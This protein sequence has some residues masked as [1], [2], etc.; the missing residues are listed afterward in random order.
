M[1]RVGCDREVSGAAGVRGVCV[2]GCVSG[3]GEGAEGFVKIDDVMAMRGRVS[4][5]TWEHEM[6]CFPPRFEDAVFGAF[7]RERHV[8]AV[9]G[10]VLAGAGRVAM[11]G[12]LGEFAVEAVIC[13]VDFGFAQAFVCLWWRCCGIANCRS[14]IAIGEGGGAWGKWIGHWQWAIGDVRVGV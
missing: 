9:P 1:V 2:V 10:A 5:G 12:R 13:G 3:A 11:E 8:R 4:R 6:L 7:R 14:P